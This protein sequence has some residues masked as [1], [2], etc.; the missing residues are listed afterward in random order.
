MLMIKTLKGRIAFIYFGLV[1]IIAV[2]GTTAVVNLFRL[3]NSIDG[4]MTANYKSIK[5][6]NQM[7][8]NLSRQDQAVTAYLS[9]NNREGIDTFINCQSSFMDYYLTE[10]NNITE[11]GEKELVEQLNHKYLEYLK[12]FS[13]LQ[14]IKNT[15]GINPALTFYRITI[16]PVSLR[17]KSLLEKITLINE[18]AMFKGKNS[19][20]RNAH[21]SV[22]LVLIISVIAVAG[23]FITS[24]FFINRFFQ[25]IYLL[26]ETVKK[27]KTGDLNQQAQIIYQDEIGVLANEFNNLTKMLQQYEQSSL[28]KL[29]AEKNKSLVIVRSI[30]DPLIVMDTN[31]RLQMINKAGEDFFAIE[32]EKAVDKHFLEVIRN[33]ELFHYISGSLELDDPET[34]QRIIPIESGGK[35]FYFNV[36]VKVVSN[37]DSVVNHIVVLFQNV[38]QLKELER[39]KTDFIATISHEFKTPLTSIMMGTSLIFNESVGVLNE[40][41]QAIMETIQ[42]DGERLES[43]VNNLLE[44]SKID[45]GQSVFKFKPCSVIGIFEKSVKSF[46]RQAESKEV[47]LYYE[48]DESMPKVR[49]DDEKIVWALNNL[50]SNALKYTNAGD[51]IVV[52]AMVKDHQ[53]YITVKDT[54]MGIPTDYQSRIFNKFVQVTGPDSEVEVRGAG[55]GLAI[56]KEIIEA[57]GG[58]IWC[59]SKL[60]LGSVFTF[61]LPLYS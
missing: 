56:V 8:E 40:K 60:D 28:G 4:L 51:E 29:M 37:I 38:T 12:S 5:A 34:N 23:G 20:N 58:G 44:L 13:E 26:T 15:Q 36:V 59:E 1:M 57:H 31:Y 50:I 9:L 48:A 43:L 32:E 25:P 17:I 52:S 41:Q 42:E 22:Y 39:V 55:L 45:S 16:L 61:T 27:V 11:P 33:G 7:I 47:R 35:E 3:S 53:M 21:Q 46:Y 30:S 6:A 54:G 49:A 18:K 24:W 14:E 10:R 19:A 2:V